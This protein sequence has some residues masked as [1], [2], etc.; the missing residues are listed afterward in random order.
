MPKGT[1][2]TKTLEGCGSKMQPTYPLLPGDL[3]AKRPDGTYG[4]IAPGLGIEGFR[5]T[6]EQEATL[7]EREYAGLEMVGM[8]EFAKEAGV[9]VRYMPPEG[10][11]E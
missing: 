11:F 5:L 7:E 3:V 4:K 9:E 8:E 2:V 6:P 1:F 10:T